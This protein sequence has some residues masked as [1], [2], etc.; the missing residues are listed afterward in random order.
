MSCATTLAR[1]ATHSSDVLQK[2]AHDLH[3]VHR[4]KIPIFIYHNVLTSSVRRRISV[5]RS[6]HFL[7]YARLE[8]V[9]NAA[10]EH[11]TKTKPNCK[12][13]LMM[14]YP[15]IASH[16][17]YC[18]K[19]QIN[20]AEDQFWQIHL[21]LNNV[22][23]LGKSTFWKDVIVCQ[24]KNIFS[25]WL[26]VPKKK[27]I[28]ISWLAGERAWHFH[29]KRRSSFSKLKSAWNLLLPSRISDIW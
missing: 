24:C 1:A 4:P 26:S 21:N 9:R 25:F 14:N 3:K 10:A 20:G 23:F 2:S 22:N 18:W 16:R 15:Y 13:N 8:P 29:V 12:I 7:K 27:E 28:D 11:G 17:E 6:G 5:N 19:Y